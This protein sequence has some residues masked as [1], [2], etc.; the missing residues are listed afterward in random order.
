VQNP[1]SS[2]DY[3]R[4]T[5]VNNNPLRFTD[6]SGYVS[7]STNTT[8]EFPNI[9][10]KDRLRG[11]KVPREKGSIDYSTFL[12]LVEFFSSFLAMKLPSLEGGMGGGNESTGIGGGGGGD[13]LWLGGGDPPNKPAKNNFGKPRYNLNLKPAPPVSDIMHA[14]YRNGEHI[15][16]VSNNYLNNLQSK[17]GP[18]KQN[19]LAIINSEL[20]LVLDFTPR[21]LLNP[22]LP[23]NSAV[24][25]KKFS[26]NSTGPATVNYWSNSVDGSLIALFYNA[27]INGKEAFSDM[28]WTRGPY[29]LSFNNGDIL[30]NNVWRDQPMFSNFFSPVLNSRGLWMAT[31]CFFYQTI[32]VPVIFN[33]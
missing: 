11:L 15:G 23:Q 29:S 33:Q 25:H 14:R 7:H 20:L 28:N 1:A 10:K 32:S 12:E 19:R 6:P 16:W 9:F 18:G 4:Y 27:L 24:N 2:Q 21:D 17:N 31:N 30:T 22:L 13:F 5:Y 26:Y 8:G 3:N